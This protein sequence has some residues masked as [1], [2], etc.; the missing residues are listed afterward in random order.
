MDGVERVLY[1]LPQITKAQTVWIFEGEKDVENM[2]AIGYCG[3]CNIGGAGKWLGSYSEALAGKD[4][5]ICG[6]ND[7]AGKKHVDLVFESIAQVA[8]SVKII[9]LPNS[10]KDASDYIALFKAADEARRAFDELV[11]SAHPNIKGKSLPVYSLAEIENDY[12]NFVRAMDENS[13]SLGKWLPTLGANLRPLVPGELV[14]FIGD[15]G[16]GKTAILAQIA[17]AAQPLA[18]VMFELELPK[19]LMFERFVSMSAKMTGSEVERNYQS[20]DGDSSQDIMAAYPKLLICPLS[21][22]TVA[23]MEDII[24][25]SELKIGERPRIVLID[26]IQLIG[27]KADTRREKISDIAEEL[28]VM[29]KATRT[30]IIVT[31]QISRP[32]DVDEKWEPSLHSAKESG[33]IESSCGLLIAAWKDF[34]EVGTLNMKVLKSTKGGAQ[35]FVKCNFDGARMIITERAQH[36]DVP[37]SRPH[38]D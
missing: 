19:E 18:T 10:V 7:E 6:D 14:F 1:R 23:Q 9:K 29:A 2:A 32:K 4:V 12:R 34:K 8:K 37:T 33:S 36:G 38:A 24:M 15:T 16:T 27:G 17:K 28:K 5:I 31:S 20:Y 22:I 11:S 35:T 30:I 13:F 3:T 26:Y 25:R 21:R